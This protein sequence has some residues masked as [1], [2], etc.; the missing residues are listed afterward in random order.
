MNLI[1]GIG[2]IK[3]KG[4][5]ELTKSKEFIGTINRYRKLKIK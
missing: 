2:K 3:L 1:S 5:K 4:R